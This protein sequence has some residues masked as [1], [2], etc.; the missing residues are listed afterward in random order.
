MTAAHCVDLASL[1]VYF[2]D[3]AGGKP[4]LIWYVAAK[5][6]NFLDTEKGEYLKICKVL[7]HEKWNPENSNEYD[8]A[9][10]FLKRPIAFDDKAYSIR[11]PTAEIANPKFLNGKKLNVSGWGRTEN[12]NIAHDGLRATDVIA[13]SNQECAKYLSNSTYI[14]HDVH[15]CAMDKNKK[16]DSCNGDSGGKIGC[17]ISSI[18]KMNINKE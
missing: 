14:I 15:L 11:L 4:K 16:K 13:I 9:L 1:N 12:G 3:F 7:V 8:L 2:Q 17:M 5:E 6:H 18:L 10:L